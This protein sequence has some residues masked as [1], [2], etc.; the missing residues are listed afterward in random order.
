MRKSLAVLLVL[1]LLAV[2]MAGV[3]AQGDDDGAGFECP[4]QGGTMITAYGADPR[5]LSGLYANDGNS[6]F[7]VTFMAEP[8]ILGGEN[9]GDKIE[10]AL[11]ESWDISDDGLEYT[12]HLRQ[13]V[14]WHDGEPFTAEDVLFTY[15]AVLLEDNAISWRANLMQGDEPMQFEVV[16]DHTFKVILSEPNAAVL[17]ALSIPIV[18]AHAFESTSM[19]EAPYNTNPITTGPFKFVEWNTGESVT[20]EANPDYWRGAPCLDRIVI[21]FIEGAANQA[22]A[23]LAGELDFARVDG[24]DLTP[25]ENNPDFVL[26]TAP[27]DLMRYVG[28]NNLSPIYGDAAVR[29][30]LAVGLDRQAIIDIS[31][32]GY[33]LLADSVFNQAV[34]MYEQG[35]NAQYEYDPEAAQQM[36][37]DAGWTD[38]DGD[39]IL[40][41]DGQP[42]HLRLAYSGT[43]SL[44]QSIAPI[45]YDNWRAL[46]VDVELAP[47]DDAQV[48]EEIYDNVSTEKPYDAMLGGWGLFGPEPDH[49]R[50]FYADATSYLAY[51]NPE[52][53]AMFAEGRTVTDEQAR[54]DLYAEIDS[55]LWEELPM[56][57]IYQSVGA[58]VYRSDLNIDAAELNGTFLTGLKYSGRVYFEN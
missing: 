51:D 8:L 2:P 47:L 4:T 54:Y 53:T 40:D 17:T 41:K 22:N 29:R 57:P 5:T 23:L 38:T 37:A 10:P 15:E 43:W 24:A 42:M 30:A 20:L 11:A 26:Q 27:R 1:V 52:I 21:R 25:F 45:V 3:M 39:G 58:W 9:W 12:F 7:I 33:G 50:S 46:G 56:I 48:Y 18:P 14:T 19:L 32:S 49:Y 13:D 36:L 28:F 6:L 55:K 34:F 44:M 31:A 16:D 35:R